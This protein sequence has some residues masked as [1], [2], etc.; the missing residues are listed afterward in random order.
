MAA[1]PI[2]GGGK[3]TSD[4]TV[5]RRR[6]EIGAATKW[7]I[8]LLVLAV[9]G[10]VLVGVVAAILV[11]SL[12]RARAAGNEAS[13]IG[14]LRAINSAQATF[15][16]FCGH[17]FYAATLADLARPPGPGETPFVSSDL[18]LDPV[19]KFGYRISLTGGEAVPDAPPAC[20]GATLVRTYFVLAE[21]LEVGATGT[22]FFA[23]NQE[24][25]IYES[26]FPIP[27]T[28]VGAPEGATP[29]R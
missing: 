15:S 14:S 12:E 11:G 4:G 26:S 23:S 2:R 8:I 6:G 28:H 7:V 1:S 29:M 18:G 25:E 9:A 24:L 5:R 10:I 27:V 13:A 17:G 16:S 22:R 3:A 19:V 20:S 21:P